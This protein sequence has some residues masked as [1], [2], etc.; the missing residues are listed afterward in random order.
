MCAA[1]ECAFLTHFCAN[2]A[3]KTIAFAVDGDAVHVDGRIS[4]RANGKP[5]HEAST[6]A[7]HKDPP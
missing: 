3:H 2:C 5:A 4:P 7:S 1:N 6:F